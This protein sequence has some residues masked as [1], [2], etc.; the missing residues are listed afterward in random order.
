M[1][2]IRFRR[3][4]EALARAGH[5]VDVTYRG[6]HTYELAPGV[7]RLPIGRARWDRYDVVKTSIHWGFDE[8]LQRGGGDH[9]F[10][11]ASLGSVVGD[12]QS[13]GVHFF[14]EMHDRLLSTQREIDGRARAVT[15]L[16]DENDR[17][18]Q[19]TH[20][21]H[22]LRL[23]VP[24]GVDALIPPAGP[25]PYRRLGVAGRAVLFA[26]NIY[27]EEQPEVNRIWVDRLNRLGRA[28][29]RRRLHLVTMGTGDRERLD[30]SVLTDLGPLP[31]ASI[32]DWQR[33]A[34]AGL[35]FAHG[36]AQD[37]ESSKIYYY[38]RTELPVLCEAP[39]PN[40]WLVEQTG[41]GAIVPLDNAEAMAD[42]AEAVAGRR[43]T[44][45]GVAEWMAREHSWDERAARYATLFEEAA[46]RRR[47]P[48]QL[49][50]AGR[51][52]S[53]PIARRHGRSANIVLL[54]PGLN[55]RAV[56]GERLVLRGFANALP[57]AFPDA[58]IAL[59][60]A[61]NGRDL[62]GRRV[63]LLVSLCTGPRLPWRA[64]DIA[65]HVDGVT[66]LW[67]VNHPELL[68]EFA[69]VPVDG[70][71][72]NSRR[73]VRVL[74]ASRPTIWCPLGVDIERFSGLP[75]DRYRAD[76]VFLGSGG[77]GNK[78][79][80]TTHHYLDPAKRFDFGLWGS[81]WSHEYWAQ[82]NGHDRGTNDWHR[83]WR[84]PLPVGDEAALYASARVVLGYHEDGQRQWGMWNNRVFE[85]LAAG[86]LLISDEAAG[87]VDE[88]GDAVVTT[89]GGEESAVQIERF[90]RD[91]R[92]RRRRGDIGRG[93]V[94]Q[95]Y[96]YHHAAA[97]LRDHYLSL[98]E[99]RG[100]APARTSPT[101][102]RPPTI[103]A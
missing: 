14:G 26:G 101:A 95:G 98:C 15:L 66:V 41:L 13:A 96:T 23:R 49:P 29:K 52:Q 75:Q 68:R 25:D 56:W 11:I 103:A 86:A 97:R 42:A 91:P 16:T 45:N 33:Y 44:E 4:A 50:P 22:Q 54:T 89:R 55:E 78:D 10:I 84:G 51:A 19:H 83:F 64:D 88:F 59:V 40:R 35:V 77:V 53:R 38:L 76:V 31:A 37:N 73:A 18:W 94:T 20:G 39:V 36:E 92:G 6:R 102:H 1:D 32:W 79:P 2:R 47:S 85:A 28:L 70:F 48:R 27:A 60:D 67:V 57:R 43:R 100:V 72:T 74:G 93:L 69:A 71:M 58:R 9:P 99:L 7:R 21:V 17:V 63:D 3:M 82:L 12:G 87:L 5:A 80:K 61:A 30:R 8:L 46:Y 65:Q 90:L 34:E 62:A 81:N 24:T